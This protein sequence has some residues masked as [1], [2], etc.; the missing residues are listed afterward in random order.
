LPGESQVFTAERSAA[1]QVVGRQL[2]EEEV[3]HR[4][5]ASILLQERVLGFSA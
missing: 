1:F 2:V 5:V 4:S 3:V